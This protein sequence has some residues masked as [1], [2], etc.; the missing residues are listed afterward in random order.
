MQINKYFNRIDKKTAVCIYLIFIL[1][2]LDNMYII[3]AVK[4]FIE[5]L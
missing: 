3:N 2:L 1:S 5:I 4:R